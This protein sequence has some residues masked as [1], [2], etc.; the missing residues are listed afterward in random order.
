[1]RGASLAA[2]VPEQDGEEAEAPPAAQSARRSPAAAPANEVKEAV[3]EAELETYDHAEQD[4]EEAEA[5]AEPND[6]VNLMLSRSRIDVN[7]LRD[8]I[9]VNLLR[10]KMLEATKMA[11]ENLLNA[12]DEEAAV[13]AYQM[14]LKA[15]D[16]ARTVEEQIQI[17]NAEAEADQAG[18]A[19]AE[20]ISVD[21]LLAKTETLLNTIDSE[22]E[23]LSAVAGAPATGDDEGVETA[24]AVPAPFAFA[25]LLGEEHEGILFGNDTEHKNEDGPLGPDTGPQNAEDGETGDS[26]Q[27]TAG[28]KDEESVP[29]DPGSEGQGTDA[30]ENGTDGQTSGSVGGGILMDTPDNDPVDLPAGAKE[31]TADNGADRGIID[32]D[33]LIARNPLLV[34][35][36]GEENDGAPD[37]MPDLPAVAFKSYG[38]AL[39]EDSLL[40]SLKS[41]WAVTAESA[42]VSS[43]VN[44]DA[45]TAD[46]D[47]ADGAE[48]HL[49]TQDAVMSPAGMSYEEL[50]QM[51]LLTTS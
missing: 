1:M 47:E 30:A 23:K 13:A 22:I 9:G 31:D 2:P 24:E 17:S 18:A 12:T 34:R 33:A 37:A 6:M 48:R 32:Q 21:E 28:G 5:D 44:G 35:E 50:A 4:G 38:E 36:T 42:S 15:E 46:A 27:K 3:R 10:G 26:G 43:D 19:A 8:E 25:E 49:F 39:D 16:T 45:S 51:V 41:D 14:L 40:D 11:E 7:L 20:Q 29:D